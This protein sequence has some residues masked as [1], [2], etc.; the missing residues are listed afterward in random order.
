MAEDI[1]ILRERQQIEKEIAEL[2][3]KGKNLTDEELAAFSKLEARKK[4]LLKAESLALK[5]QQKLQSQSYTLQSKLSGLQDEIGQRV[6]RNGRFVFEL[7]HGF[8]IAQSNMAPMIAGGV[9]LKNSFGD[10]GKL[11]DTL[12]VSVQR[13]SELLEGTDDNVNKIL[14]SLEE[15]EQQRQIDI[16]VDKSELEELQKQ[17]EGFFTAKSGVDYKVDP[18]VQKN[19]QERLKQIEMSNQA[20]EAFINIQDRMREATDRMGSSMGDVA[21]LQASSLGLA[22]EM[23]MNYDKVGT[24]GFSSSV[25]KAEELAEQTKRQAKIVRTEVLPD[26][27][28]KIKFIAKEAAMLPEGSKQREAAAEF[29][30]MMKEDMADLEASSVEMVETAKRNVA[31]AEQMRIANSAVASG[32]ELILKPFQKL[33]SLLE[34]A[35][36]GKYFAALFDTEGKMKEFTDTVQKNLLGAVTPD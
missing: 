18:N 21:G 3:K 9:N 7:A 1:R 24:A 12:G 2:R 28:K 11:M 16:N 17:A 15:A 19:A 25:D 6:K 27:A 31:Q 30:S 8:R 23:A 20:G 29:I 33:N 34:S 10:M 5:E 22:K 26:M 14:G 4:S 35:P 13:S 32:A 36:G